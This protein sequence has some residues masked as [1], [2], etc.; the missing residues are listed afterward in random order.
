MKKFLVII[1]V[2][3]TALSVSAQDY[4]FKVLAS[5]G[6]NQ[7]N[8]ESSWAA[9]TSGTKITEGNKIKVVSGG[10]VGLIS[11]TGKVLELK[12]SGEYSTTDLNKQL[13]G[14]DNN[15]VAKYSDFVINQ[16]SG[17]GDSKYNYEVTGSVDR[18]AGDEV[19]LLAPKDIVIMKSVPVEISWMGKSEEGY[20]IRIQNFFNQVLYKK[21]VEGD[22]I[23]LDLSEVS[24]LQI[25]TD[26][27]VK[28]V[29]KSNGE[30]SKMHMLKIL[31]KSTETEV[32]NEYAKIQKE[33]DSKSAMGNLVFASFFEEKELPIYSLEKFEKAI[34]LQPEVTDFEITYKHYLASKG[35]HVK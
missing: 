32:L 10:Y 15:F 9:L 4:V 31:D 33:L 34:E 35:V 12:K 1:T 22:K 3:L 23:T 17:E 26:Y 19:Q 28:V 7:I 8:K 13:S 30:E 2:F 16:M 29:A 21:T 24:S 27:I 6:S 5:K 11:S 20:E 18:G 14:G 25:G